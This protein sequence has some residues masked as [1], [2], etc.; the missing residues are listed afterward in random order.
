MEALLFIE[1]VR[2]GYQV[3]TGKRCTFIAERNSERSYI[4]FAYSLRNQQAYDR[5]VAELAALPDPGK[6][7]L[8]VMQ[9]P[10][11]CEFNPAIQPVALLDWL[12]QPDQ[13]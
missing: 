3:S 13:A 8:I 4:Q 9:S 2:R 7:S 5:A 1:L 11:I 6:R 12:A 10:D